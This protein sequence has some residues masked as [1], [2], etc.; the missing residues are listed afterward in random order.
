MPK[1]NYTSGERV[2]IETLLSHYSNKELSGARV[3]WKI[4]SGASGHFEV[5]KSINRTRVETLA[6]VSFVAPNVDKPRRE[7]FFIEA[8]ARDNS[9]IAENSYDLFVFPKL[10]LAQKTALIV[11]D[12]AGSLALAGKLASAGYNVSAD[13][14][15]SDAGSKK[16]MIA[17]V[18]DDAVERHLRGGGRVIVLANSKDALP[19]RLPFKVTPRAGSDLDGNWVTNF[20]WIKRDAAPFRDVA[21]APLLGF[22]SAATVPQY[23]IQNVR[24]EDY[25]DV[26]SGIF[27]GWLNNNAALAMQMRVGEGKAFVTTFRFNAYGSDPYPT[28]LL[29]SMIRYASGSD[30]APKLALP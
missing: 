18:Y 22:E 27:Y 23:V 11:H 26:M 28:R 12:P 10:S 6:P 3:S 15:I 4:T 5:G 7:Q 9:L 2:T 13:A 17:T 30:F 8:R 19:A 25:A 14:N 16:L 21:F 1:I 29:D 20:N 24:A